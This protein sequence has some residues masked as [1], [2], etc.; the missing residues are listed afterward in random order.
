M[1]LSN[2][3]LFQLHRAHTVHNF[4]IVN[5]CSTEISTTYVHITPSPRFILVTRIHQEYIHTG[6]NRQGTNI[7][8]LHNRMT[9]LLYFTVLS[10]CSSLSRSMLLDAAPYFSFCLL[11]SL[12]DVS[13]VPPLSS[14]FPSMT[15]FPTV[16]PFGIDGK[17]STDNIMLPPSIS[18]P[19]FF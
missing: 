7:L 19:G 12:T 18:L 11:C 3:N 8:D 13:G 4:H 17:T 5:P 6:L 14:P 15:T 16:S 2:I 10:L 1:I 9:L